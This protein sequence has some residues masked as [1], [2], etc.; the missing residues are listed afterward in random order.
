MTF[1]LPFRCYLF[2]IKPSR[3]LFSANVEKCCNIVLQH[4]SMSALL[5]VFLI[6][7]FFFSKS[8]RFLCFKGTI[9]RLGKLF[10]CIKGFSSFFHNNER[11]SFEKNPSL[12]YVS[13]T[14]CNLLT[15]YALKNINKQYF[16]IQKLQRA[17]SLAAHEISVSFPFFFL[18]IKLSNCRKK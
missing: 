12:S 7:V 16:I 4:F 10:L 5:F 11:L 14:V 8:S 17:K 1:F 3:F 13:S 15:I 2:N 18:P 6:A 9:G